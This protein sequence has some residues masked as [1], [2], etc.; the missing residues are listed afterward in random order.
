MR[1]LDSNATHGRISRSNS[2]H[3]VALLN[4]FHAANK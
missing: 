1:D 4:S 2:A 3:M